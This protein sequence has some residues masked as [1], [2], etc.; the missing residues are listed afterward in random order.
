MMDAL[1]LT[2][3][4][5]WNMSCKASLLIVVSLMVRKA[6][7]HHLPKRTFTVLWGICVLRLLIPMTVE[8]PTNIRN[9]LRKTRLH[10]FSKN[11]SLFRESRT[12]IF[13]EMGSWVEEEMDI[14]GQSSGRMSD[15]EPLVEAL[16]VIW[17][18]GAMILGIYFLVV[19]VRYRRLFSESLPV[20]GRIQWKSGLIRSVQLRSSDRITAPLSYG[21]IHP[22]ILFPASM[23]WSDETAISMIL[24]HEEIHIRRFD[25]LFKGALTLCLCLHW[26]NPMVWTLFYLGNRDVELDCD[27]TVIRKSELDLR[28]EYALVLIRMEERRGACGILY[29]HFSE[30][31]IEERITEIMRIKKTTGLVIICALCLV[32][33]FTMVFATDDPEMK[34]EELIWPAESCNLITMNFGEQVHPVTGET[35][36]FDYIIISDSKGDAEGS[37]VLAAASGTVVEAGFDSTLGYYVV[38]DH[39]NGLMTKYT[40][41]KELLV[42]AGQEIDQGETIASVGMTGMVTGPCLGFYVYRDG[43]AVDPILSME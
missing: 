11:A 6:L 33:G 7:F 9:L 23:D 12:V 43:L 13:D 24:N 22:V 42:Q 36:M 17:I 10:T 1:W 34:K 28:K 35:K 26:Y 16:S 14:L 29:N 2:S 30:N 21:M 38:I 32:I 3:S 18:L 15:V 39:G 4:C 31:A 41:C 37:A 5:F 40:H 25:G 19:Y 8:S 20:E 27:E